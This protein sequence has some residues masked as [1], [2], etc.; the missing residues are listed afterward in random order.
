M[1]Q[2]F[3]DYLALSN[4]AAVANGFADNGEMWLDAFTSDLPDDYDFRA[5]LEE[6]WAQTKP[7]Y[8]KVTRNC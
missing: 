8:E 7:L 4:E 6:L 1:R 5:D 2:Q 3:I